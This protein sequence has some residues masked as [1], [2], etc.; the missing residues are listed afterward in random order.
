MHNT[1][2]ECALFFLFC[3]ANY[4]LFPKFRMEHDFNLFEDLAPIIK[5]K[6]KHEPGPHKKNRLNLDILNT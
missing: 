2:E 6:A 4:Y 3:T 1:D 5:N